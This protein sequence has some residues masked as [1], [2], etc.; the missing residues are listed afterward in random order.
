VLLG[1]EAVNFL[2]GQVFLSQALG[3][4]SFIHRLQFL[5]AEGLV[6]GLEIPHEVFRLLLKTVD[7]VQHSVEVPQIE[8]EFSQ[9]GELLLHLPVAVRPPQVV[10][11]SVAPPASLL[12]ISLVVHHCSF[13]PIQGF[14]RNLPLSPLIRLRTSTS[15]HS[16][17]QDAQLVLKTCENGVR[18]STCSL[19]V[20]EGAQR[21]H[22]LQLPP[23]SNQL[24]HL[25]HQ[26]L[27]HISQNWLRKIGLL[28]SP[29]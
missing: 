26:T 3:S 28:S 25:P 17:L 7:F 11:S 13:A 16:L 18:S 21:L 27:V 6:E 12:Q 14:A 15:S 2:S 19:D 4:P 23:W 29:S 22:D 9:I 1:V 24:L 10:E 5:V 20:A 8:P